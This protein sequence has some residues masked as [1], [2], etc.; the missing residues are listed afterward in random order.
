MDMESRCSFT[1]LLSSATVT[2]ERI[3]SKWGNAGRLEVLCSLASGPFESKLNLPT[4]VLHISGIMN[5][6]LSRHKP[7]YLTQNQALWEISHTVDVCRRRDG[8]V[9]I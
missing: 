4:Y 2:S 3:I 9:R 7:S 1:L 5:C 6:N 8:D